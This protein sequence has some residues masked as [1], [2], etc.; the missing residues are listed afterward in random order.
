MRG[1]PLSQP[2]THSS[3]ALKEVTTE[4]VVPPC[5]LPF[6]DPPSPRLSPH[7][8]NPG[9]WPLQREPGK[10]DGPKGS[11]ALYLKAPVR[12]WYPLTVARVPNWDC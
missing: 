11:R 1:S 3:L 2:A 5:S 10:E 8:A 9:F 7:L 12:K 4:L 6:N